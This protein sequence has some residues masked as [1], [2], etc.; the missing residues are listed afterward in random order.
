MFDTG[1]TLLAVGSQV[2]FCTCCSS[3]ICTCRRLF[4]VVTNSTACWLMTVDHGH[5]KFS[6]K[7]LFSSGV[8]LLTDKYVE[9]EK[10]LIDDFRR[11]YD[12]GD[13]QRMK[14]I[15]AI[16]SNFKVILHIVLTTLIDL[17]HGLMVTLITTHGLSRRNVCLSKWRNLLLSH[18]LLVFGDTKTLPK[19]QCN[20]PQWGHQVSLGCVRVS[21]SRLAVAYILQTV[22]L[23]L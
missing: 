18:I 6:T 10:Q 5:S 8:V 20:H 12:D 13:L 14:N 2:T 19:F 15:T 3:S 23:Q 22:K 1:L 17:S 21:I 9:I 16:L 11:A 4:N 7:W